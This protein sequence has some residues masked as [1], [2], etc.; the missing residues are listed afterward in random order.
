MF[1]AKVTLLALCVLCIVSCQA[2]SE[3][4]SN[5][6]DVKDGGEHMLPL[7]FMLAQNGAP[8]I[9]PTLGVYL[10]SLLSLGIVY[11]FSQCA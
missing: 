1:A 6:N 10:F 8:T 9:M 5:K 7:L 11:L 4:D 3:S 2:T